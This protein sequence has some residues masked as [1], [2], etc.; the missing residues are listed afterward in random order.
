MGFFVFFSETSLDYVN[1]K[2]GDGSRGKDLISKFSYVG[3]ATPGDLDVGFEDHGNWNMLTNDKVE[4][5]DFS[6][7]AFKSG[8]TINVVGGCRTAVDGDKPGEKSVIE[9]FSD[10]VDSKSTIKGSDVRVYY[11]GGV[12]NDKQLVKPNNGNVVEINGKK[13]D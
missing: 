12:V 4:P 5:S 9:Q 11:P 7:D 2:T 13:K 3:H 10:K 1:D 6:S 8:C